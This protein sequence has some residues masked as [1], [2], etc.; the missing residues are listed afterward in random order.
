MQSR[1][2]RVSMMQHGAQSTKLRETILMQSL[3]KSGLM[4]KGSKL[5]SSFYTMMS[6]LAS[7]LEMTQEQEQIL[8]K[9]VEKNKA[10]YDGNIK[11]MKPICIEVAV[12]FL[13]EQAAKITRTLTKAHHVLLQNFLDFKQR[14]ESFLEQREFILESWK[15]AE[16]ALAQKSPV[17]EAEYALDMDTPLKLY[18]CLT[19][20]MKHHRRLRIDLEKRVFIDDFRE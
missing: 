10:I 8:E 19:P 14:N 17:M 15:T 2:S 16:K 4:T 5:G 1:Q 11:N 9:K 12:E 18:D 3:A 20:M 6:G 7:E 13:R